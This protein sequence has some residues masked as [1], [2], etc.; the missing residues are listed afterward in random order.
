[1]V[2]VEQRLAHQ[3][4]RL[5]IQQRGQPGE[6]IA[7]NYTHF[8]GM[9]SRIGIACRNLL[10]VHVREPHVQGVLREEH[11]RAERHFDVRG[12]RNRLANRN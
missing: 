7:F 5:V 3:H 6:E 9:D 2:I 8:Y 4:Q 11:I 12:M 10:F 1:M